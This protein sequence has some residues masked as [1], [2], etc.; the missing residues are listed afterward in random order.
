MKDILEPFLY[1]QNLLLLGLL[2]AC[3]GYRKK[4]LWLLLIFYYLAGNTWLANHMRQLYSSQIAEQVITAG[5]TT[6]LLGCGGSAT[7]LPTCAKA[8]I[9][10]LVRIM[11]PR[12]SVLITTEHC[13]PYVDYLL[14][15]QR[16]LA[17][18]CFYGGDNTYQEFSSL[19]ARGIKAD[20]IITSDFHAWRVSQLIQ[21]HGFNSRVIATSSQ[22]FRPVNCSYNC[23]LTVNLTNF[24]FYSKLTAEFASYGVY[25]LTRNWTDWYQ[26]PST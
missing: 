10:H 25:L 1:P 6:V 9:N 7:A 13:K 3:I 2:L 17:M 19:A 5:N 8:R 4:G 16:E 18:D 23:F 22:T 15:Q 11:P 20:Y 14:A 24:D 21:R 12:S 26:E